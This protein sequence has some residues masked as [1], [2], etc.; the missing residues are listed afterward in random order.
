MIAS[1][2][3]QGPV[4]PMGARGEPG[5]EGPMVGSISDLRPSLS[6]FL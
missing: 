3:N 4:G 6:S 1:F 5:F 2:L